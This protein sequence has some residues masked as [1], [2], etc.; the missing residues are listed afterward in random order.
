MR[1]SR[2]GEAFPMGATVVGKKAV[3][4][5]SKINRKKET[6]L[7]L[8]E[9]TTGE[10]EEY[11]LTEEYRIG[12]MYSIVIE[13]IEPSKYTYNYLENGK[14]ILDP[15]AKVIC[16]NE[17]W[18]E[19]EKRLISAG[20]RIE[21]FKWEDDKILMHPYENSVIYQLHVR[22]F[23]KHISS[24]V[25]KKGTYEGII[26]KI[27]YLKELGITAIELL[28]SYEFMEC[29]KEPPKVLTMDYVKE[30][31]MTVPEEKPVTKINYWGFKESC[32]FAPKAAYSAGKNPINSFKNMVK[33][34]HKSDIEVVMQF[35]FP[36]TVERSYILEVIKYW[37]KEYHIDGVRLLGVNIPV[38]VIAT[39]PELLNTKIMYEYMP[40]HEIYDYRYAPAYKNLA[41]YNDEYLYAVRRFLKGDI[42]SLQ[43]AF[44]ALNREQNQFANMVYL[45][46]YNTFTL[47]DMVS[48]ERKHN[49]D[50]GENGRDGN[51]HNLSWNCGIE[52]PTKKKNVIALRERQMRNAIAFLML[53][54]GTPV[55]VAGDE[56][57]NSQG[58]NNN[59]Y[60]QD[61]TVSWLNW[62]DLNKNQAHFRFTKS[63]I[64]FMKDHSF[65]KKS[66]EQTVRRNGEEY[67][68]MSFHG[69]DAWKLEWSAA[70]EEAGGILYYSDY[71][72]M[73]IGFNMHWQE[74]ILALPNVPGGHKWE[75]LLDTSLEQE[76]K[77]IGEIE[78]TISI[79]PRTI[80]IIVAKGSK[81]DFDESVSAF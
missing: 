55:I 37:V 69:T 71:T 52:G 35:F 42:G 14:E 28:P 64:S 34:L 80:K 51:N 23:T 68:Y 36:Q 43:A 66:K 1:N 72:Y 27:P 7:V 9:K 12:N 45:T 53:S 26:E 30:N 46:N 22:G 54:K 74:N 32:Y 78:K 79:P 48:F 41:V 18:G 57:G 44:H 31:Y 59:P 33:E 3:Q 16:G 56:F 67:P 4:F 49:E 47:K 17:V 6:S 81:D 24:G 62:K 77:W 13:D 19:D 73:Y 2:I 40:I 11:K 39:Q 75:V 29:E 8:Y 70:N 63:M 15:Y 21:N 76:E 60:C 20:I 65:I 61:N 25:K 50:N 10:E 38:S 58:G 5:V